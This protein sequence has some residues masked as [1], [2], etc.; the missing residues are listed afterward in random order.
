MSTT[1]EQLELEVKS[2]SS[3]AVSGIDAL[4]AS[5]SKLKTATSGG[6]GL[7]S[8]ANQLTKIN[9]ALQGVNGSNVSKM[10][11]LAASLQKL[12]NLGSLK[13]SSS[14]GN[15]LS[16]IAQAA[17]TLNGVDFSG[18]NDLSDSLGKFASFDASGLKSAVNALTKIPNI[19]SSFNAMDLTTFCSQLNQ[20]SSS[21]SPL[22]TQLNTVSN[23]VSKLPSNLQKASNATNQ[24]S[25]A[26]KKA[27]TSYVN[28]YAKLKVFA[29]SINTIG[30]S[31]A[32]LITSSNQY[33]EDMNLFTVAMGEY[34][35]SAQEYAT[36]VGDIMGINPGE[37]MRNQGTFNTIIKGFGVASD[38]AA[39]MSQNLT[40]LGYDISS[41][42]NISFEN[43]MQKLQSGI[44]GE[45]E[46]LRRLGYDLSVAR[47]QQEAYNLG[48][49]KSV[50]SMTQAEKSQ[51]RYYAIMTQVTDA[52]GD[53]AR[54]LNAPANQLRILQA[55]L[56]QCAIALGNIFLPALS[57]ILPYAIAVAKVIRYLAE[58]IASLF[59]FEIQDY[60]AA[61]SSSSVSVGNL[62]SDT[63]DAMDDL[64][65]STGSVA[66]GLDD[67]TKAAKKLKNATIG[68][69]ELNIISPDTDTSSSSGGSGGSGGSVDVGGGSGFDI[70]LATY[71][72]LGEATSKANEIFE[73]MKTKLNDILKIVGAIGFAFASWKIAKGITQ[74]MEW[75][76]TMKGF[77]LLGSIT[78]KVAGL[79]LFLDAWTTIKEAVQD[80]MDNGANFEN[81]TKLLSGFAEGIGAA[82]LM[83]GKIKTAG[84]MLVIS[85]ILGIMSSIN[86]IINEGANFDNVTTLVKN[87]GLL[88]SGLGLAFGN[89]QVGGIGLVITGV[90]II[91]RNFGDLVEAIRT[92]DW[93]G[94]DKVSLVAGVATT[95]AGLIMAIKKIKTAV[96]SSGGA[97]S[98]ASTSMQTVTTATEQVG[99]GM[100]T[101]TTKLQSFATNLLWGIAII[102]EI[103]AAVLIIVGTI[104]LMGILLNQVAIAWTPVIANS[105]T[106][107]TAMTTGALLIAG[108]GVVTA[109]LGT[110]G[111]VMVTQLGVGILVLAEISAATD[112]FLAEI[113]LVGVL[114]NQIYEA[115]TPVNQNGDKIAE[116]IAVGTAILVAI[117]VVTAALGV[118]SVA[119][120]GLLPL[121]IAAGTALLVE[122]AAAFV[123]FCESLIA[124]ANELE[125]RLAPELSSLNAVLP[126]LKDD[127]SDFVDFMTAFAGEI[128]RYTAVDVVAGLAA[129]IDTIIGWFTQDPLEKFAS[130]IEK[131]TGQTVTLN[132]K[133]NEAVPE[134]EEADGL[135][136][137]YQNYMTRIGELTNANVQLAEGT[138]VNMY[139]VGQK[140]VTGFVEGIQSKS[141]D[142]SNAANTLINGFK[143][144]LNTKADNCKTSI[145]TWAKNLKTWF[146]SDSYG[147]I[148]SKTWTNYAKDI[149]NGFKNGI[150]NNWNNSKST[151]TS[152]ANNVKSWFNSPNGNRTLY[153]EF[154]DIGKNVIQG[155]INGETNS[156][157][158]NEA[159]RQIKEFGKQV[160]ASGKQ[161]LKEQSPSK[162]FKEIGAFVIEGFNIGLS[163]MIDSSYSLMNEWTQGVSAYAPALALAVDTS[164]LSDINNV[165]S[166]NRAVVA[167]VQSNYTVKSD[168]FADNMEVFYHNYVEPTL[169]SIANDTKRQADKN[170]Q[171]IIKIGN[172]TITDAVTT[173]RRANGYAFV[174]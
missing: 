98:T 81:V 37:F 61:L 5:L 10:N 70:P 88:V 85:G 160:I 144:T 57:A 49:D 89:F 15:Q 64:S 4:S 67:A 22:A 121:A 12:G 123:A 34:A 145:T 53:M 76:T 86:D 124:T 138:F 28:F 105:G 117:G 1:I 36:Q 2:N 25:T 73:S 103:C 107:I 147:G 100:S 149:V 167:D 141:S 60:T 112:L 119:T 55:Q 115:W 59:G 137:D 20:L 48:I 43:A 169:V 109:L 3:S 156:A 29:G 94:V 127:M 150:S 40:Q 65:D 26:N 125:D 102:G 16:S 54:T 87:V 113:W 172:K 146:T 8:I 139:E 92:G 13:L 77:D 18:I 75:L 83:L 50:S 132:E 158:W 17:T 136:E 63:T 108:I 135:L 159:K 133:L 38:K 122:L 153:Y 21:L 27:T 91:V 51:L 24:L 128:V 171:T 58:Q 95:I 134:L 41:F 142:F 164:Q 72:F 130:D 66:S 45:L 39:T 9:T 120:A 69:D 97:L 19:A 46:P 173:Q 143:N 7:T 96:D 148:S 110:L 111:S 114:L 56:E 42:Y 101:L 165:P 52:Q 151:V 93:S 74:F 118:A 78:F 6:V 90:T 163:S 168:S 161:G 106:V 129:T 47:L 35:A 31:I 33:I 11:A 162:A 82:L 30:R 166:V 32:S 14:F 152:W 80:I 44:S 157:L 62:V 104:A 71:D 155:F 140:I 154:S 131:I 170:E 84:A 174:G 68:I 79:G 99:T 126:D 23:A 116:Y